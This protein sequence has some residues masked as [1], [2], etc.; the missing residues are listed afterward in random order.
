MVGS[1]RNRIGDWCRSCGQGRG[2]LSVAGPTSALGQG[3]PR[4]GLL[5]VVQAGGMS[6]P[7]FPEQ[8]ART[9][10]FSLGA[11]RDPV[12]APDGDRLLFLRSRG[13]A[14]LVTC[15]WELDLDTGVERLVADARELTGDIDEVPAEERRRR[16]RA[17]ESAGGIVA[18]ATDRAV[19]VVV[20]ALSGRLF[21][22]SL[23]DGGNV[24]ELPAAGP[25]LSPRP[26]PTG[27]VVAY[28]SGGGLRVIG[29]DGTGDQVLVAPDGPDVGWGLAE[30]VAAEEMGRQRG[31][32]WSPDG[33][34]LLVARVDESHVQRWYMTD[35]ANPAVPPRSVAYPAAG[36]ANADV[37]LSILRLDGSRVDV[38]WDRVAFEYLVT[39]SWETTGVLV[40]VQSRDQ[41]TMRLLRID[42]AT[43]ATAVVRE[44][45]D[46]AWVDITAGVPA[47]TAAGGLVWSATSEDTHRLLLDGVPITAAGLQLRQVFGVDGDTVLFAASEEPTEIHVWTWNPTDGLIRRS[48]QPGVYDGRLAGGTLVLTGRTWDTTAMTVHRGATI[49]TVASF[50]AVSTVIPRV[51]LIR[52]GA[53]ELRTAVLFPS[54]HQPGSGPLPVLMDPYGGP[55]AQRVLAA[56]D[57]YRISQWFADQGFAV[58][59]A[60]GRGTP[61][62]GPG[63]ERSIHYD[64][65]GPALEDQVAALHAAAVTYPD[66]DLA[67]VGIRGWS[68]GGYLA[69]LA[70]LR[71]PDVFHAAIAGAPDID[72]RLY[73][74][75]FKERYLGHPDAHPEVYDQCSLTGDASRLRRPLMLVHGLAD[76][77]VVIA[78]TLRMSTALLAAGK[79]HTVL[80]LTGATHLANDPNVLRLELDFLQHALP[81]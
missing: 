79:P 40:V 54:G 81:A 28:V 7:S 52:A 5:R 25:V 61:G 41:R 34:R 21:L 46:R 56:R 4:V 77:N 20:F 30:F 38:D 10:R 51:Q 22:L 3:N 69:A 43:G 2:Y 71:R 65:A 13:G 39:A 45:H 9:R 63:W 6:E 72:Q 24:R 47:V 32:W 1:R 42:P 67:R 17:R 70:V 74:T 44:D 62:R 14:D 78:H 60:D 11:P 15:L 66:L 27:S 37:S 36:T 73:D 49:V 26:D 68:Y 23:A 29:V 8:Y 19:R 55:A 58:V 80:P 48:A 75:H 64:I 57:L 53:R 31:F 18:Y 50:A 12:L 16:E 33:A 76:D 59:I 35:P